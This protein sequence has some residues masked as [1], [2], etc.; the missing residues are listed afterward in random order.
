LRGISLLWSQQVTTYQSLTGKTFVLTGSLIGL[1]RSQAEATIKQAGGKI[2]SQV[3]RQ[4]DY[5]VVGSDPGSKLAKAK[6]LGVKIIN[7]DELVILLD[8]K[9]DN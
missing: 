1:T 6:Q 4:T 7:E 5:L 2:G 3:G 8:N 9:A